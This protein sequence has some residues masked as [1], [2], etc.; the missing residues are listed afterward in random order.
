MSLPSALG[1]VVSAVKHGD[2]QILKW[3]VLSFVFGSVLV[4]VSRS[5][6]HPKGFIRRFASSRR[7]T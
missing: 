1:R 5:V 3:L 6:G 7:A 4:T 2:S